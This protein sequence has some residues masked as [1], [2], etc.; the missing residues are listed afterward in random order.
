MKDSKIVAR[1]LCAACLLQAMLIPGLAA[2]TGAPE[3]SFVRSRVYT[4]GQFSDVSGG[5]WFASSVKDAYELGLM[6]GIG[7]G[8]FN[9]SGPVQVSE[10]VA[11]CCRLHSIYSGGDGS[12]SQQG[13]P[14]YQVYVDYALEQGILEEGQFQ[15]EAPAARWQCAVLMDAALPRAALP[16]VNS[17]SRWSIPDVEPEARY[18]PAVYRLYNAG[19]FSGSDDEGSFRPDSSILRC[20]IAAV[21]SRMADPALRRT[22]SLAQPDYSAMSGVELAY[23]DLESAPEALRPEILRA[24]LPIIYGQQG[25]TVDGVASVFGPDGEGKL[26]EFSDLWPEW[27][28]PYGP[29]WRKY[30]VTDPEDKG[31]SF[32][33]TF[34]MGVS[35][36]SGYWEFVLQN[37]GDTDCY[38]TIKEAYEDHAVVYTSQVIPAHTRQE[39][40]CAPDAPLPPGFYSVSVHSVQE[41]VSPV[42]TLWHYQAA[43]YEELTG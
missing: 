11:L 17:I 29:E 36:E 20:E 14:W 39:V 10:V 15:Y 3:Q 23:L 33:T 24:R 22:F 31:I 9:P 8:A 30:G 41:G 18:A 5:D 7:G 1:V 19:V 43:S 42:G 4:D 37:D 12:F 26:P 16:A 34:P 32:Y 35:E 27:T 38:F 6:E 25:W 13:E 40:F 21:A 2:G 28:V